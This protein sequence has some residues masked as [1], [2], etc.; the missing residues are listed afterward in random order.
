MRH[1]STRS[2]ADY[3]RSFYTLAHARLASQYT[4]SVVII[5]ITIVV[6]SHPPWMECIINRSTERERE[7]AECCRARDA[8]KI[9][10]WWKEFLCAKCII[11]TRQAHYRARGFESLL[12]WEAE[13]WTTPEKRLMMASSSPD[14]ALAFGAHCAS[15]VLA[16]F[17]KQMHSTN[18]CLYLRL[19]AALSFVI[20]FKQYDISFAQL[21]L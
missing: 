16:V 1:R 15:A 20:C 3:Q 8:K 11:L 21:V 10:P 2:S 18:S 13:H 9:Q 19:K 12:K 7:W 6:A 4:G 14:S 17:D 5:I